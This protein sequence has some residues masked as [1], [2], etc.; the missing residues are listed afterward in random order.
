MSLSSADRSDGR[1]TGLQR[2]RLSGRSGRERAPAEPTGRAASFWSMTVRPTTTPEVAAALS[3]GRRSM[4]IHY[5]R[6][7]N[8]GPA[9][10][11]NRGVAMVES[12]LIAFQS[13][14]DIWIAGKDCAARCAALETAPIWCSA[15]CRT[16]S[17]RS[18]MPPPPLACN[19]RRSRCPATSAGTLLTRLEP[20]AR[21][22]RSMNAFASA[23]SSTGTAAPS[24]LGLKIRDAAARWSPMRRLH[25]KNHSLSR[26]SEATSA[27]P[28]W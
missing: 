3:R 15:T 25:G 16:S 24:D 28:M 5:V 27:T 23:S 18:W 19:A 10:A 1:D 8:A 21:S 9:A 13:A 12:A 17:A 4:P 14:D 2:R 7:D 26:K 20:F 22:G 11:I 6:Q